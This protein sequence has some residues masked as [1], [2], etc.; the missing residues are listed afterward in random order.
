[1][2]KSFINLW[3]GSRSD[4]KIF[5]EQKLFFNG[6][7]SLFPA[8]RYQMVSKDIEYSAQLMY[9]VIL[10]LDSPIIPT[11]A[12]HRSK[13]YM[14]V[15]KRWQNL[16]LWVTTFKKDSLGNACLLCVCFSGAYKWNEERGERIRCQKRWLVWFHGLR[17]SRGDVRKLCLSNDWLFLCKWST[18]LGQVLGAEHAPSHVYQAA[19]EAESSLWLELLISTWALWCTR[20][21][22]PMSLRLKALVFCDTDTQVALLLAFQVLPC[23]NL[24]GLVPHQ[25]SLLTW[26]GF[27]ELPDQTAA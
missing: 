10:K 6:N 19:P 22:Q 24:R 5:S 1:M 20:T 27:E 26:T 21:R 8:Q 23:V 15:S 13:S 18:Y 11:F 4:F 16:H 17:K 25:A 2:A 14:K 9:F 12:F 3:R 7:F